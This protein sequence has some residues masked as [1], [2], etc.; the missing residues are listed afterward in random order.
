MRNKNDSY[1]TQMEA[2]KQGIITPEMQIVAEKEFISPEELRELV[3][4]GE[5]AIPCNVRHTS[6]SP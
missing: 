2:A 4:R 5:V 3:V 6:I 1:K